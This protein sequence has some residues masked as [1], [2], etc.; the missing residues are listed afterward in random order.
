MI[1]G[2][3]DGRGPDY[4]PTTEVDSGVEEADRSGVRHDGPSSPDASGGRARLPRW[5]PIVLAV[6]LLSLLL[7]GPPLV[8]ALIADEG[9]TAQPTAPA[10]P[11]IPPGDDPG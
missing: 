5:L 7:M 8:R 11:T 4:H 2:Y 1:G 6:A 10:P 3:A 9:G